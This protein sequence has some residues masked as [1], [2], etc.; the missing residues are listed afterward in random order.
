METSKVIILTNWRISD[1]GG[2]LLQAKRMLAEV[3]DT[4]RL[5]GGITIFW[6]LPSEKFAKKA[7][8]NVCFCFP[9]KIP[10]FARRIPNFF[11]LFGSFGSHSTIRIIKTISLVKS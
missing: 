6:R 5:S 2:F 10:V 7:S 8:R 9:K 1:F 11:L 3:A 4:Q